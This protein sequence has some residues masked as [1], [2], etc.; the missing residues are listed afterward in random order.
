MRSLSKQ[1]LKVF[2]NKNEKWLSTV[3]STVLD[4]TV[5]LTDDQLTYYHLAKTFADREL[6]PDAKVWDSNSKFPQATFKKFA[7]VGFGGFLVNEDMGGSQLTRLNSVILIEALATGCVS[8]TSML[9]IHNAC[10]NLIDKF[11]SESQRQ[12]WVPQLCSLEIMASF[13]LT[14]PGT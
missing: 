3:I 7:S 8:L 4:P 12:Q 1:V 9:T 13:C 10:A 2:T 6:R 5:G 14:E 11:G